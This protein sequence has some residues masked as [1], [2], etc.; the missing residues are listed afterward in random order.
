MEKFHV[1]D[2]KVA[3]CVHLDNNSFIK[4]KIGI[5]ENAINKGGIN[6]FGKKVGNYDKIN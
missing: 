4:L 3:E 5:K 1:S 6:L 2:V